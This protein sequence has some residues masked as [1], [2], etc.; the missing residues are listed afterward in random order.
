MLALPNFRRSKYLDWYCGVAMELLWMAG[1]VDLGLHL[2]AN[3]CIFSLRR[4]QLRT[5]I[6]ASEMVS[7]PPNPLTGGRFFYGRSLELRMQMAEPRSKRLAFQARQPLFEEVT[8]A[9]RK[10]GTTRAEFARQALRSELQR[11][12]AEGR[13]LTG[14]QLLKLDVLAREL[15]V[16]IEDC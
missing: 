12:H 8:T 2:G 15:G 13:R 16:K 3:Q 14:E 4:F 7:Q 1:V 11:D 9:A 6:D 10:R 5:G